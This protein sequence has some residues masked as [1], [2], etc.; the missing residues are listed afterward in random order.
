MGSVSIIISEREEATP[1][2]AISISSFILK[3]SAERQERNMWIPIK[4]NCPTNLGDLWQ[5]AAL[6]KTL[7]ELHPC[8]G[9]P[10]CWQP[11]D[12]AREADKRLQRARDQVWFRVKF[13]R[14]P[15]ICSPTAVNKSR[16]ENT[17][18]YSM[19]VCTQWLCKLVLILLGNHAL[20]PAPA[21]YGK[22]Q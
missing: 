2:I 4:A 7:V 19:C 14:P 5:K 6:M 21:V 9:R 13:T 8:S 12:A 3:D 10:V 22:H 18:R 20:W 11:P 1:C 16:G 15:T 17:D